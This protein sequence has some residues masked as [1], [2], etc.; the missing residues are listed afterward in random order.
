MDGVCHTGA[1]GGGPLSQA[2]IA[3]VSSEDSGWAKIT[4]YFCIR[5]WYNILGNENHNNELWKLGWQVHTEPSTSRYLSSGGLNL[6][7]PTLSQIE[8]INL[9]K[10]LFRGRDDCYGEGK[11][12]C[13]KESLSDNVIKDHLSGIR[14]IGVYLLYGKEKNE[15]SFSVMD[16][17][18]DEN[19]PNPISRLG[20]A[21]E[22][23]NMC[24]SYGLNAQIEASKTKGSYHVWHFFS[25]PVSA[26]KNRRLMAQII[27]S[28][29]IK[30]FEIFPKQDQTET[31][32]NYINLPLFKADLPNNTAFIDEMNQPIKDQWQF[33]QKIL[34]STP[35]KLDE[36]IEING[37]NLSNNGHKPSNQTRVI[38]GDIS[39]VVDGCL[40]IK[41]CIDKADSL[42]EPL[43]YAMICNLFALPGGREKIH[44]F[45]EP[46]KNYT[47]E[48][49]QEKI[50][51]ALNDTPGPT[52]CQ[53][54]KELGFTCDKQCNVKAPA[55]LAYK[56]STVTPLVTEVATEKPIEF[57]KTTDYGNAE[58]LVYYHG[59]DLR[60]CETKKSWFVWNGQYWKPDNS[61]E[62]DRL[63]KDTVRKVYIEAGNC[64]DAK[65]RDNVSAH[66]RK[67]E[68][69]SKIQ[70]MIALAKSEK[71]VIISFDE[72]GTDKFLLNC[73]NGTIDLRTGE[74]LPHNRKDNITKMIP[75]IYDKMSEC[76]RWMRFLDEIF[77]SDRDMIQFVQYALGY[78]LTGSIQERCMFIAYGSGANGK[79]KFLDTIEYITG[80]YSRH[81]EPSTFAAKR[82]EAGNARE[83]IARLCGA[84]FISSIETSASHRLNEELVK[85]MTGDRLITTRNLYES[86]FEFEQ[87]YKMWLATNNKPIIKGTDDGI[88]DRI[89]LIPFE[90]KFLPEEQDG[91][92]YEK[93]IAEASGILYWIVEGCL[94]WQRRSLHAVTP[95]KVMHANEEYRAEMNTIQAF[96]DDCCIIDINVKA[97]SKE[98]YQSYCEWCIA[99][100]ERSESQRMFGNRLLG[101]KHD[102][103]SRR[104]GDNKRSFLGIGIQI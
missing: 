55:G 40:F 69:N 101:L 61:L 75:A 62:I 37:I 17:D 4:V 84:R 35:E 99:N 25:E 31:Y 19:D 45:S 90:R 47:Y 9:F 81:V 74:L 8:K 88:W 12:L 16:F 89:R 65:I 13:I 15:L 100:G 23:Y 83:D 102:I 66:A 2:G 73:Q 43:W 49:T 60:Y 46:Y 50:E 54:I 58:R 91:N 71:D 51:H 92:L 79:S 1:G 3:G 24:L 21:L 85:K 36:I 20:D 44:E 77:R 42:P 28:T 98:L 57:F 30:R 41:H 63:A 52:T 59:R 96:I 27:S 10:N 18:N 64:V 7:T 72:L 14:R 29:N 22:Y 53:Q 94:L 32:G 48:G 93:L 95:D 26:L 11:G 86:S 38:A 78:S 82:D 80:D 39:K 56:A 70:A 67:S 5:V 104:T 34:K 97:A 68:A 103:I 33:L 6:D 76:P 87:T